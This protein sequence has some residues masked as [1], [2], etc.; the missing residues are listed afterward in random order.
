MASKSRQRFLCVDCKVDT[1]KINEHYFIRTD[2]WLKVMP[3]IYGMLCIGC[4]EK[5][6]GRKLRKTDFTDAF[7][8][9]P[10]FEPKSQRLMNRLTAA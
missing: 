3:T 4:L 7:I 5:R 1:G 6:L 2:L 9:S 10:K 8:N